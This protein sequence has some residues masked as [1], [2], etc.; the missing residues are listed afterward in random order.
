MKYLIVNASPVILLGKIGKLSLL[1]TLERSIL[2]TPEVAREVGSTSP[3]AIALQ[4]A[5]DEKWISIAKSEPSQIKAIVKGELATGE[6][7]VIALTL[8]L[9]NEGSDALAVLDD[10]PARNTA[11]ALGIPITG[12]LGIIIY[13]AR[14]KQISKQE[15]IASVERLLETGAR[16]DPLVVRRAMGEIE[17]D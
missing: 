14:K 13:A 8:K 16:L 3:E 2:I 9:K 10:K 7:E 15:A 12:T 4:K 11:E 5:I 1:K 6:L 17:R